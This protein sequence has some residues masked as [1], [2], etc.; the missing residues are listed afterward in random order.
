MRSINGWFWLSSAETNLGRHIEPDEYAETRNRLSKQSSSAI[1][2]ITKRQN[3][4]LGVAAPF[5][6]LRAMVGSLQAQYSA[7]MWS[8]CHTPLLRWQTNSHQSCF[9]E[10]ASS[11]KKVPSSPPGSQRLRL[12]GRIFNST[13]D[14]YVHPRQISPQARES[15]TISHF[16]E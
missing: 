14:T 11:E 2:L 10:S 1:H 9:A 8:N 3:K 15:C 12:R 6:E 13:Y 4:D 5:R 16:M 7:V